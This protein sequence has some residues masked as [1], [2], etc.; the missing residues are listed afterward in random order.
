MAWSPFDLAKYPIEKFLRTTVNIWKKC[1]WWQL[2]W[3]FEHQELFL[4]RNVSEPVEP[5]KI[6]RMFIKRFLVMVM[7]AMSIGHT[8]GCYTHGQFGSVKSR[9]EY[10]KLPLS[11]G[12]FL[13]LTIGFQFHWHFLLMVVIIINLKPKSLLRDSGLFFVANNQLLFCNI[14]ISHNQSRILV[15]WRFK[16]TVFFIWCQQTDNPIF[17][18]RTRLKGYNVQFERVRRTRKCTRIHFLVLCH[19]VTRCS[20]LA[21]PLY[22]SFNLSP[23]KPVWNLESLIFIL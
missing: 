21:T 11:I 16:W 8:Y 19:S 20:I 10:L 7:L 15:L 9:G 13:K 4:P 17:M 1:D 12:F 2:L 3:R 14:L 23:S 6:I 18:K 5:V 22:I